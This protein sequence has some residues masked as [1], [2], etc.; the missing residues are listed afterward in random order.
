LTVKAPGE[1]LVPGKIL[2][3]GDLNLLVIRVPVDRGDSSGDF[4]ALGSG[5]LAFPLAKEHW[6]QRS[7]SDPEVET[8]FPIPPQFGAPTDLIQGWP[9]PR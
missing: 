4:P 2:K 6:Q 1:W 3:P 9:V 8:G 7:S 5:N